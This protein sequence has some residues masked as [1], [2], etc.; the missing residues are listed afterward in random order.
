MQAVDAGVIGRAGER[1]PLVEQGGER[2]IAVLDVIEQS[3]FH[4]SIRTTVGSRALRHPLIP[5]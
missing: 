5:G 1:E 2:A 3:D 4:M